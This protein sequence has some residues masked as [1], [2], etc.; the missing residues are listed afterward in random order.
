MIRLGLVGFSDGNGHPYSWAAIFNGY[1]PQIMAD[2]PYKV[3]PEYLSAQ[4]YPQDFLSRKGQVVCLMDWEGQQTDLARHVMGASKIEHLVSTPQEMIPL[5]DAVLLAR[6]DGQNHLEMA[7]PFL[8]AGLPIFIDKPMALNTAHV[9][10]LWD[11]QRF[12]GQIFSCS[13]LRFAPEFTPPPTLDPREIRR[14]VGFVPKYW[15]TYG[16][17]LID[18]L[19]NFLEK[20]FM[21]MKKSK[22]HTKENKNIP[23]WLFSCLKE[24]ESTS[25]AQGRQVRYVFEDDFEV[26]LH[27]TGSDSQKK[28]VLLEMETE[29]TKVWRS[30]VLDSFSCFRSS[31]DFFVHQIPTPLSEVEREKEA[32]RQYGTVY[33]LEQG[34]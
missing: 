29:K 2:C 15:E 19:W 5:V 22:I 25:S 16:M 7:R 10:E 27:A 32:Q 26:V 13:A 28:G 4:K 12:E 23:F 33:L 30:G 31:L 8:E 3:I 21:P 17:H 20:K 9:E 24:V 11:L 6:D 34:C 18:P 1:D 14:I